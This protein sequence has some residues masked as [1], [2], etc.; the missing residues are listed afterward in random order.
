MRGT[1]SSEK[2][3]RFLTVGTEN[4]KHPLWPLI[5]QK[6]SIFHTQHEKWQNPGLP[7]VWI[8]QG[9]KWTANLPL[10]VEKKSREWIQTP[11]QYPQHTPSITQHITQSLSWV[12]AANDSWKAYCAQMHGTLFRCRPINP[13]NIRCP[14]A[15]AASSNARALNHPW[16]WRGWMPGMVKWSQVAHLSEDSKTTTNFPLWTITFWNRVLDTKEVSSKWVKCV[17][18][19]RVLGYEKKIYRVSASRSS[20]RDR[21][22]PVLVL[23]IR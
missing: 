23:P 15:H 14:H 13:N 22:G 7:D 21:L 16:A 17:D 4:I 11:T 5:P 19:A 18:W 20:P 2:S 8:S 6:P 12:H 3:L 9:E 10:L 1:L